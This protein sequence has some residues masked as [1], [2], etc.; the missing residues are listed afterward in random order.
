M[1]ID[2]ALLGMETEEI[3][4]SS[5]QSEARLDTFFE[6]ADFGLD[7]ADADELIMKLPRGKVAKVSRQRLK[8]CRSDDELREL[9]RSLY[10]SAGL[11]PAEF[12]L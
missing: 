7:Q 1:D 8:A 6:A 11:N 2:L 12:G 5:R 3:L 9:D 10:R 4:Q